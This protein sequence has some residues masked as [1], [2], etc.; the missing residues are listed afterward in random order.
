MTMKNMIQRKILILCSI[1]ISLTACD[2]IHPHVF[3][4]VAL[5]SDVK[6]N[7]VHTPS[8]QEKSVIQKN[9]Q[10]SKIDAQEPYEIYK[11]TGAFVD[12]QNTPSSGTQRKGTVILNFENAELTEVARVILNDTLQTNYVIDPR[13]AGKVSLRTA[14]ALTNEELLSTLEM[15]L[16]LNNA[17]LV[18]TGSSYRIQMQSTELGAKGLPTKLSG[19]SLSAGYQVRIIPLLF[20]G[21]KQMNEILK[22]VLSN[23]A[24]LRVDSSRN[25][26]MVA[27]TSEEIA[28]IEDTVNMFDVNTMQGMSFGLFPLHSID[29]D[30]INK[31]LAEVF[32]YNAEGPL[33][34]MF[35]IVPIERLNSILVITPQA[36]YLEQIKTWLLRLDR[37][38]K[39]DGGNVHVYRAQHMKALD[40]AN[41][42]NEIFG[43][44]RVK[45]KLKT[46]KKSS[47]VPN[48][49]SGLATNKTEVDKNSASSNISSGAMDTPSSATSR[50]NSNNLDDDKEKVSTSDVRIIPDELNNSLIIVANDL[51]YKNVS[52]LINQLDIMPLQVHIDASILSVDLDDNTKYG[53]EWKFDNNLG[54]KYTGTGQFNALTNAA[55]DALTYAPGGF[56]YLIS[57]SKDIQATLYAMASQKNVHVVS[58][59]SL[60]VLNNQEASI[61][62]GDKIPVRTSQSTNTNSGNGVGTSPIQTSSIEM[63]ETGV[64]LSVT[65]RVNASG[66]VIMDIDQSVDDATQTTSSGIDSPTILKRSIKTTVA[67][68]SNE[69]IVLGGLISENSSDDKSGIPV[70][71][72]IPWVGDLFS[73]TAR[74]KKRKELVVLITPQVLQNKNDAKA[75]A[76]E[77]KQRLQGIYK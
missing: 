51:D 9:K 7:N 32:G 6:L 76:Q 1:P 52:G 31:E 11:G 69:T 15:L 37:T 26:L 36:Q 64:T 28:I 4:K 47:V 43:Q 45:S 20:V 22:P 44:A 59:P 21:A 42:L 10:D 71:M 58:S 77:Y 48:Q 24:L 5:E 25:L 19:S 2:M 56:S 67:V 70:L 57:K 54:G 12:N 49:K 63:I 39:G 38:K 46:V 3:D 13:I 23:N 74:S 68:D 55:T 72:D 30:T 34:D 41:T 65:P 40:L 16:Q 73:T 35:R 14:K 29:P 27:G 66:I 53:L 60:M 33:E 50:T 62:V 17:V 75:V 18:K 8:Q 61:Q